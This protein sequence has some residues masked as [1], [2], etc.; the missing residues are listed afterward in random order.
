MTLHEIKQLLNAEVLCGNDCLEREAGGVFSS[1]M[2][3]DVLA[4]GE[5]HS[6][7][8]TGLCNPQVVRTA[9]M[10]DIY[11]VIFASEKQPNLQIIKL[12][13]EKEI[14]VLTTNLPIF[15][16]CGLLYESGLRGNS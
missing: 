13:E 14:V 12:A 1:D 9:E 3:S 4:F 8:V 5:G 2:M 6:I 11:C 10:M 16:T 7:L 15:T